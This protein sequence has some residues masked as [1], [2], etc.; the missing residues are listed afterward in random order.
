MPTD[1]LLPRP[2]QANIAKLAG[3]SRPTVSLVLSGGPGPSKATQRKVI[4]VAKR[5]GYRPNLLVRGMKSGKSQS[6]GILVPP[7]DSYWAEVLRGIHDE[8]VGAEYIPILMWAHQSTIQ[9]TKFDS[10]LIPEREANDG[11]KVI[12]HLLDRRVDA[13]ILWPPFAALYEQHIHE[14]LSRKVPVVTIDHDLPRAFNTDSVSANDRAGGK[15]A[16]THLLELGHR[17]LGHLTG[18]LNHSWARDRRDGFEKTVR[19][20]P[21][22]TCTTVELTSSCPVVEK[23][24]ELLQHKPRPTAVFAGIDTIAAGLYKAA[25]KLGLKIP[26]DLSVVGFADLSFS[27][28]LTPPLTT[29]KPDSY[30]IGR[31]AASLAVDRVEGR[32]Q[33]TKAQKLQ[34]AVDLTLRA[35]TRAV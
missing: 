21:G 12:Y 15:L 14:F 9:P 29:I 11:L 25:A 32:I 18:F 23:A 19:A 31:R 20:F 30:N 8:L 2:T 27:P 28:W 6:V 10:S 35:S 34:M 24:M 4:A 3:V 17:R 5:L 33:T 7:V 22:A 13:V 16:A 1:P 26:R